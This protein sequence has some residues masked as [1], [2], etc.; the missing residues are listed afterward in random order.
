M[1]GYDGY[2]QMWKLHAMDTTTHSTS[3][4]RSFTSLNGSVQLQQRANGLDAEVPAFAVNNLVSELPLNAS[5]F[6]D[7][8]PDRSRMAAYPC[9]QVRGHAGNGVHEANCISRYG[10]MQLPNMELGGVQHWDMDTT[11]ERARDILAAN[12][13]RMIDAGETS[14]LALV[15][16][17]AGS[18]GT[19]SRIRNA[20]SSAGVDQLDS[21]GHALDLEPWQ[22]IHPEPAL[23]GMG[24]EHRAVLLEVGRRLAAI[25]AEGLEKAA[26]LLAFALDSA[27]RET[28]PADEAEPIQPPARGAARQSRLPTAPTPALR[29]KQSAN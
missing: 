5:R 26:A 1:G 28:A 23:A 3:R 19:V 11:P 7:Q 6:S 17:G 20:Q 9:T 25:P 2:I 15:R 18:L 21:M 10:N 12:V 13:N 4:N 14:L 16:H 24:A 22:L 8:R 29:Q 27:T